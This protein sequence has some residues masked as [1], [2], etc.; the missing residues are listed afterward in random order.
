MKYFY[1]QPKESGDRP[2]QQAETPKKSGSG[3]HGGKLPEVN[4]S[5][6]PTS[7]KRILSSKSRTH[8]L[9][10]THDSSGNL[11]ESN[12]YISDLS[13][14]LKDWVENEYDLATSIMDYPSVTQVVVEVFPN[15]NEIWDFCVAYCL[16]AMARRQDPTEL[17]TIAAGDIGVYYMAAL[18]LFYSI[19]EA[20]AGRIPPIQMMSKELRDMLYAAAPTNLLNRAWVVNWDEYDL[21][22]LINSLPYNS[23]KNPGLT[24]APLLK[25]EDLTGRTNIETV[26]LNVTFEDLNEVGPQAFEIV[27]RYLLGD[28]GNKRLYPYTEDGDTTNIAMFAFSRDPN[29]VNPVDGFRQVVLEAPLK[30]RDIAYYSLNFFGDNI[31]RRDGWSPRTAQISTIPMM[32]LIM[33]GSEKVP[34]NVKYQTHMINFQTILYNF[35]TQAVSAVYN[36]RDDRTIQGVINA[37]T[38][39]DGYLD[40]ATAGQ[41]ITAVLQW[42]SRRLC[43]YSAWAAGT[44]MPEENCTVIGAGSRYMTFQYVD[45]YHTFLPLIEQLAG[46]SAFL[47]AYDDLMAIPVL[48]SRGD[49]QS[50]DYNALGGNS[51]TS[52][53]YQLYPQLAP[54]GVSYNLPVQGQLPDVIDFSSAA[55]VSLTSGSSPRLAG[56]I[57]NDIVSSLQAYCAI[58]DAVGSRDG[59]YHKGLYITHY[60]SDDIDG[61]GFDI[62]ALQ[63]VT[64]VLA[65]CPV[66]SKSIATSLSCFAPVMYG[67]A[68]G[69]LIGA[70][71]VLYSRNNSIRVDEEY[72][73]YRAAREVADGHKRAANIN[74]PDEY[75]THIAHRTYI[76]EGG[77]FF[78]LLAKG[79]KIL[80]TGSKL[81]GHVLDLL[82]P[83]AAKKLNGY[84]E[85]GK[86]GMQELVG[87]HPHLMVHF[88][89]VS[90]GMATPDLLF[91]A[92][93]HLE[94]TK[95]LSFER[96]FGGRIKANKGVRLPHSSGRKDSKILKRRGG[97][98]KRRYLKH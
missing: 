81:F 29:A 21:L 30:Q 47:D 55:T 18:T 85:R 91:A 11:I 84:I 89:P 37:G 3:F 1:A 63:Q 20:S 52:V 64:A 98:G 56:D 65:T 12:D 67:P 4:L 93:H 83:E 70:Y 68:N 80:D 27:Q 86:K 15:P 44:I 7:N 8:N 53:L 16:S 34:K 96:Q 26:K 5:G 58:G 54:P 9:T 23:Y 60:L 72:R 87:R 19:E 48:V 43:M 2:V 22:S 25:T 31:G 17:I 61:M 24:L 71:Q 50:L 75:S 62:T 14:Q 36:S 92:V 57:V 74:A 95:G 90:H 13:I 82:A 77:A 32:N 6:A 41:I 66:T 46:T 45:N 76:G 73:S 28:F 42:A 40:T 10:G 38:L 88:D 49:L 35:L 97:K 39:S 78:S 33:N 79:G 94:S 69:N 51:L 59:S